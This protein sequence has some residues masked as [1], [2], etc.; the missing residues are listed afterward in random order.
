MNSEIWK[1]K[2]SEVGKSLASAVFA[3]AVFG[4]GTVLS[5]VIGAP[6][7]NLFAVDWLTVLQNATNAAITASYTAFI[8]TISGYFVRDK[9]GS[10]FGVW[11]GNGKQEPK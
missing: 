10:Y 5:G 9:N 8:G 6:D 1:V 4:F 7:F 11:G 2:F 3:A